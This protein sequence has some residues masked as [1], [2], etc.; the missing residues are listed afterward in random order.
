MEIVDG[1]NPNKVKYFDLRDY[2]D[3]IKIDPFVL[4]HMEK[5]NR[6]FDT[7]MK[8]INICEEED[9]I[10]LWIMNT[11]EEIVKS[12]QI[13]NHFIKKQDILKEN[14]FFDTLKM[15]H[16]RIH[17]LHHFVM[18]DNS[19]MTGYRNEPIKVSAIYKDKTEKVFWYRPEPE[20]VE[21]FMDTF[22]KVYKSSDMSV[23]NSNSFLKSALIQLLF[24]RIH[25]YM[26]GNGRT[27]R[28]LHSI[29]LTESI[30]KIYGKNY[31]LCPLN[32]SA[33]VLINQ[34][35]YVNILNNLY[36]DL[37]HDNTEYINKWF[38]FVLNMID[39][40]LYYQG[41]KLESLKDAFDL[42]KCDDQKFKEMMSRILND[43]IALDDINDYDQEK[44]YKLLK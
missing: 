24:I 40:Q 35:T 22:I 41:S 33:S 4:E 17:E 7:Y 23:I 18:Q 29:K 25:P 16:N 1:Q 10:H 6:N 27:S 32:I 44:V 30:N 12:N 19:E 21:K 11:A 28:V 14:L 31:R 38:N 8:R 42:Y 43:M 9:V 15:S 5:T 37:E 34:I 2:I 36:F 20:D 26:D 13:E 3:N 39:E